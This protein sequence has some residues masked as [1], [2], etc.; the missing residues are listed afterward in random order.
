MSESVYDGPLA[1]R[2]GPEWVALPTG[3]QV[4]AAMGEPASDPLRV[5]TA[6]A[7]VG[8]VT[9]AARGYTRGRGFEPLSHNVADDIAGVITTAAMRL[10]SNP[11]SARR[12]EA[13]N[14]STVPGSFEGWTTSEL[15]ALRRYRRTSA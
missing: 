3:T 13:G 14:F 2:T 15:S 10:F 8:L 1:G 11:T 4:L 12:I 7:L 6:E 5:A 9:T